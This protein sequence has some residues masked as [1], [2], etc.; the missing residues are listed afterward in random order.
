MHATIQ[1]SFLYLSFLS[2]NTKIKLYRT[3]IFLVILYGWETWFVTLRE[4]L[5][6]G[7]SEKRVPMKMFGPER[8]KVTGD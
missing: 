6:L 3:I 8:D 5:S 1:S 7:V 4:E 2:E